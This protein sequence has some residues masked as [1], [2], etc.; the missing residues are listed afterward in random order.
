M[1]ADPHYI[2]CARAA[3]AILIERA[4]THQERRELK[5]ELAE[6]EREQGDGSRDTRR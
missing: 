2:E 6:I 5:R 4:K 1:S 3:Y